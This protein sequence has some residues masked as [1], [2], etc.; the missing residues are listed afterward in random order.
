M[1]LPNFRTSIFTKHGKTAD[2]RKRKL[3]AL[4]VKP[5]ETKKAAALASKVQKPTAPS[6]TGMAERIAALTRHTSALQAQLYV[7]K[8]AQAQLTQDLKRAQHEL[9]QAQAKLNS[10]NAERQKAVKRYYEINC[11]YSK[12]A[13]KYNELCDMVQASIC[14]PIDPYG[15]F[16]DDGLNGTFC[17]PELKAEINADLAETQAR[18]LSIQLGDN[19]PP[20][21]P[22][23]PLDAAKPWE[24]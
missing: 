24:L 14:A 12:L 21:P 13:D 9:A 10:N 7:A 19:T 8:Q 16:G 15:S 5:H 18:Q 17:S 20:P 2:A 6:T 22:A 1:V 23:R 3:A 4:A 11:N